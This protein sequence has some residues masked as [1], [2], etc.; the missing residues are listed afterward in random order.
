ML[1]EAAFNVIIFIIV[2]VSTVVIIVHVS[3]LLEQAKKALRTKRMKIF[4]RAEKYIKE[5]RTVEKQEIDLIR[6]AK[7]EGSVIVPAEAKL[8]FVI[9]IRG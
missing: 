4:R 7:K 9:R 2:T 6:S 3:R 1:H 8:A 5:D